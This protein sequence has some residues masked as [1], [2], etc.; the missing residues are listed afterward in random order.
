MYFCRISSPIHAYPLTQHETEL[1]QW[2]LNY[3]LDNTSHLHISQSNDQLVDYEELIDFILRAEAFRKRTHN[4]HRHARSDNGNNLPLQTIPSVSS[5]YTLSS[6]EKPLSSRVI[7][8]SQINIAQASTTT[9]M[10]RHA[11][12]E[13]K[14]PNHPPISSAKPKKIE[15][16]WIQ[17]NNI[18]LPFIVKNQGRLVSYEM[19]IA[20][21][22]LESNESTSMLTPATASDI[23]LMNTMAVNL[24]INSPEFSEHCE[25]IDI[26]YILIRAKK[27]I[28]MKIL[29]NDSPSSKMNRQYPS[30]LALRGGF[31]TIS[32]QTVPFVRS[33]DQCYVSLTAIRTIYP[34][35]YTQFKRLARVPHINEFDYL[36]LVQMYSMK[37]E[38]PSDTV[39][40]STKDLRQQHI[41]PSKSL[42]L[43]EYH[44]TEKATFESFIRS[45]KKRKNLKSD[46]QPKPDSS[47]SAESTSKR[48]RAR[49]R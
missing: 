18:Y 10:V 40:I 14:P 42:T 9:A 8:D 23:T 27:L 21:K 37:D 16:G 30:V 6:I 1:M 25:L 3:H 11:P 35:L 4:I 29:P 32:N 31:L 19:L 28:Y 22:I 47:K 38:L 26:R 17:I 45:T 46:S 20:N 2:I 12:S 5:V 49:A 43:A 48:R 15:S 34:V 44:A 41:I 36:Q 7:S 39:L 24:K 13:S 33:N